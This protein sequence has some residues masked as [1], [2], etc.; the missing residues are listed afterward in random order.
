MSDDQAS[1]YERIRGQ[2]L[3][4]VMQLDER[5]TAQQQTWAHEYLDANELGLA[6][7]MI[8]EWL[9]EDSRAITAAER[10]AMLGLVDEM[11]MSDRVARALA[12]CPPVADEGETA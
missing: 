4:L 8:A 6:L 2:L 10:N 11:G 7:E 5:L 1:Y 12:F 3:G 9:S